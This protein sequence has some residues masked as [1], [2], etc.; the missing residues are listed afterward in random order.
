VRVRA[1]GP[2]DAHILRDYLRLSIFV[3]AGDPP[4]PADILER[5]QIACYIEGW[6]RYGDDAVMAVDDT[7]GAD[8]GA[9]WLRL[10]PGP[11]TGYGFVDRATPELGIAVRPEHRGRGIGTCLLDALLDRASHRYRAVSLSVALDNPAVALYQRLGFRAIAESQRTLT[12][13]L[14]FARSGR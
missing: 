9:A 12:M 3:R 14:T 6:G 13:R 4:L 5:P 2:E 11:E 8:L 7:S 1:V 10:W